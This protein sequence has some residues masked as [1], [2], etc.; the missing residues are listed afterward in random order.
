MSLVAISVE[1][2]SPNLLDQQPKFWILLL[3]VSNS[4]DPDLSIVQ[5]LQGVN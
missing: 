4:G 3:E 2:E 5:R 1:F